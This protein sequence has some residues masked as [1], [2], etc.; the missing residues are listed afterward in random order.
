MVSNVDLYIKLAVGL[1]VGIFLPSAVSAEPHPGPHKAAVSVSAAVNALPGQRHSQV[2]ES[3]K[4][5]SEES[6]NIQFDRTDAIRPLTAP[7]AGSVQNAEKTERQSQAQATPVDSFDM[8]GVKGGKEEA[9]IKPQ[10][11]VSEESKAQAKESAPSV[12]AKTEDGKKQITFQFDS[13]GAGCP[14]FENVGL[15]G[16][17]NDQTG[18]FDQHWNGDKV[19]PMHD[20]GLNGDAVAGDGIFS[21]TV[22]LKAG[23]NQQ[24]SWGV[25]GDITGKDGSVQNAQ[26]LVMTDTNPNF[27]LDDSPVQTYAP[28]QT[29]LFGVHKE[30]DNGVRF[31]TWSPE[32]GKGDLADYK[33]YVEI[34]NPQTGEIEARLPMEKNEQNGV[35]TLTKED[36]WADLKGKTYQY[37]A[38]NDKGEVLKDK[39]G[40]DVRYSD[41]NARYLQGEQ[42]GLERIFVDPVL[43]FETGWYDDSG[44][45]GPNYADNQQWARFNVDNHDNADSVRLVL[46]DENG[47]Q[48]TKAELVERLGEAK[49]TPYDKAA[50]DDKRDVDVLKSWLLDKT[51]GIGKYNWIDHVNEDGSIDMTK[52]E[53]PGAGV[54]WVTAVN[55]FPELVGMSYEFQV[56]EDGKLVG[57]VNG[58][59][60]LSASERMATPFNDPYTNVIQPKPGSARKSLIRESSFEFQYGN[61]PRRQTDP[62]NFVIYE[63]H[64][65]SFM[66]SKDNAVPGTFEDMIN[67]L[68]Y[69]ASLGVDTIELMP[70][71]EFGGKKDWGYTPDFYY[72]GADTYGFEMDRQQ[73]IDRKLI[74]PD[75]Q[76]GADKVWI[77]GT[78]ALKLFVD[79]S[80][81]RGFNVMA[82]VVYNHTSGR[83]DA[84]DPLG[85]IDGGKRSFFNWYQRG[86]SNTPWGAKPNFANQSVKDFYSDNAVQQVTEFG[87]DGI[88]FDF[89]QV[90]H[91]TGSTDEQIEGMNTLRQINRTLRM[92][93]PDVYTVAED[94]SGSW[95]VSEDPSKSE[96][97]GQGPGSWEKK[98][99]GFSA[100][101]NDRFHDDLLEMAQ[102]VGN[103][104][105]LMEALTCHCGVSDWSHA[106]TYAHS[107]DEV[108]NTG[109]WMHRGAAA[110]KDDEAVKKPYPRAVARTAEAITLTGPGV[111]MIFQGEE[112]LANNDFKHGLTSTWGAD[113]SWLSF[114]VTPDKLDN[115]S[116]LASMDVS[117]REVERSRM[118]PDEQALFDRYCEM[119]PEERAQAEDLS[120][121]AGQFAL[122]RDLIA[123]RRTSD[124]F[125]ATGNVSR[126][127]T[128]NDDRVLA[129]KRDNGKGDEYVI[130]ANFANADRDGYRME[131]PPGNWKEVFNTNARCYGGSG[132]G[133]G[134]SSVV[135]YGGVNLPAGSTIILKKQ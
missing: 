55:N 81:K 34:S 19:I 6:M 118:S 123:L 125:S 11:V 68:D 59:G 61:V 27:N 78:D 62:K 14:K 12:Q 100:V 40:G 110:S 101:W 133:N 113:M 24:F 124:A 17:F 102:G 117:Q 75:E 48:L 51:E 97:Q 31:Q 104:D 5:N 109:N 91:S 28:I 121:Q 129:V 63:A 35:W 47:K 115:F 76:E 16:S 99:M 39:W 60:K 64:V 36:G 119:N 127:Y 49:F 79:E 38:L 84:D 42:R 53:S 37:A 65:G 43:G 134:G 135:S 128:H 25:V 33:L 66:S 120:N 13:R 52:I 112:F 126:V 8:S 15:K 20:D 70:T 116:K 111:P 94:F 45:G 95:L 89:T 9:V 41:P 29:H 10:R 132:T 105:R 54:S 74:S 30:G 86:E 3:E 96:W 50:P 58:D 82:D 130:I 87:F 80:H 88:R 107:H 71:N 4:N 1:A 21:A 44:K 108:G 93:N 92:V 67:N 57:D 18:M 131:L 114:N 32:M 106:V 23:Q 73:A 98:G 2:R 83:P 103:A 90:L 56:V 77:S 7:T 85:R 122:T 26:W 22:G 46:R 69:F 72:A